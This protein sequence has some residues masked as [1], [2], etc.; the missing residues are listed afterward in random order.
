MSRSSMRNHTG[1]LT[2]WPAGEAPADC[3]CRRIDE[4]EADKIAVLPDNSVDAAVCAYPLSIACNLPKFEPKGNVMTRKAPPR[5]R[6]HF[7]RGLTLLAIVGLA[8]A[9]AWSAP[10]VG[11]SASGP[12]NLGDPIQQFLV[13][14][15]VLGTDASG[16]PMLYGSTYNSNPNGVWFFA[17]SPADGRVVEKLF[18][19]GAWG[20]YHDAVAADGKVYLATLTQDGTPTLW[21]YD[22]QTDKV[23][24]VARIPKIRTGY[25]FAFGV[26]TSPWGEV[27]IGVAPTGEVYQYDPGSG[28]LTKLNV[29]GVAADPKALAALPGKRLLI[30]SGAP[31]KL[32]VY[33]VQKGTSTQVLPAAYQG[34]SFAYNVAVTQNDVFVE[35]V[36]P[37]PNRILRFRAND[38]SFVGET[39]TDQGVNWNTGI[40]SSG[41]GIYIAGTQYDPATKTYGATNYYE[42]RL[43]QGATT[44]ASPPSP[45]PLVQ[46]DWVGKDAW[47][48]N[49]DGQ[50]WIASIGATGL[51]GRWNPTT[52]Q[53]VLQ[54]LDLPGSPTDITALA[55][56]PNGDI[57]GG[58]YETNSLF[59]YDPASG[60]TH[61][62]GVVARGETGEIL[63]LTSAAGR[64]FMGS[65]INAILTAYDPSQPWNPGSSSG[66]NPIDLGA[67]GVPGGVTQYRPWD[68]TVGD[69]GNVYFVSG[70]AYGQ[71]GGALTRIT[72]ST[73]QKT[74]WEKLAPSPYQDQ[75]LFAIAPG[76]GELYLGTTDHGDSATA[77]GDAHLLVWNEAS[78]TV[79]SSVVPVPGATWIVG[80]VTA[81][82]GM[83]YGSTETGAWFE[84]NPVTRSV[85][86]LG[87]FP[88]GP[89]LG[90]I[91]GPDGKIYG[92]TSD[93]IFSVDPATNSVVKI[94]DTTSDDRY[95]T[96]AFDA[97]GRL[98]FASGPSLMRITP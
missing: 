79:T 29:S 6:I 65:Y 90:M 21:M 76:K 11:R 72:P 43:P 70:A 73:L 17:V 51:F 26:T 84:Y 68:T 95:H 74:A 46:G 93:A 62:F 89:A 54:Q 20:G 85:T 18:M 12:E 71:L 1:R 87:A 58:T 34:Y 66:S 96:D 56:G 41:N 92:H 49:I 91:N 48:V 77:T 80:L 38:M 59:S 24:I 4:P 64:I 23:G 40:V 28:N 75:N 78:Q 57:Y 31:A 27:Y 37:Q 52:G 50:Q 94:A 69:D 15:T 83:V 42:Q 9:V 30:G 8:L 25:E 33:D 19:P 97:Q 60:E 86:N 32:T 2:R 14:D 67:A 5:P 44:G 16:Q 13:L 45:T 39:P 63:S 88:Y 35:M 22:P 61:N 10:A 55:T 81:S 47:P 3:R 98:Y 53:L 82:N 7:A 36:T